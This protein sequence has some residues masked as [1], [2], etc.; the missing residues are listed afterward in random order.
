MLAAIT[1][2]LYQVHCPDRL[3]NKPRTPSFQDL[4]VIYGYSFPPPVPSFDPCPSLGA[5]WA[6]RPNCLPLKGGKFVR[7]I[8]DAFRRLCHA[9]ELECLESLGTKMDAVSFHAASLNES[10]VLR[11]TMCCTKTKELEEVSKRIKKKKDWCIERWKSS[12]LFSIWLLSL[13]LRR[14]KIVFPS[15]KFKLGRE[16]IH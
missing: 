6:F 2:P 5:S 14:S 10:F 9:I 11:I 13:P 15:R 7:V 12:F 8:F 3:L 16:N 1:R 4:I